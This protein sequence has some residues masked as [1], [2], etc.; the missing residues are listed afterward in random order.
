MLRCADFSFS[1]R[2]KLVN[3]SANKEAPESIRAC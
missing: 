2:E 1:V 3:F